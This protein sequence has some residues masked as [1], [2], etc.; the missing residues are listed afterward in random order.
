MRYIPTIALLIAVGVA[1]SFA[2]YKPE[3]ASLNSIVNADFSVSITNSNYFIREGDNNPIDVVVNFSGI[4]RPLQLSIK[5]DNPKHL[6]YMNIEMD[7]TQVN[8]GQTSKLIRFKLN[9]ENLPFKQHQRKLKLVAFNNNI[10]ISKDINFTVAPVEA[11]NVY[12]LAGQSNMVGASLSRDKVS[13]IED[14]KDLNNYDATNN[15]IKQLNVTSNNFD[16]F[17][18]PEKFTNIDLIAKPPYFITAEDP[19][20]QPDNLKGG[21]TVGLGLSFAKKVLEITEQDIILVPAAWGD[22]G[23]CKIPGRPFHSWN[24]L[25][26]GKGH[27]GGTSMFDR[28][29]ARTNFA[30][31]QSGGVLRGILWQQGE[32]DTYINECASEYKE[33]LKNIFKALRERITYDKRGDIARGELSD[34]PVTI[35]TNSRGNDERGDFSNFNKKENLIDQAHKTASSY[36]NRAASSVHDDLVPPNYPCG[37]R[38]CVHYGAKAYREMG[39]RH[40]NAYLQAANNTLNEVTAPTTMPS[41]NSGLVEGGFYKIDGTNIT[42]FNNNTCLHLNNNQSIQPENNLDLIGSSDP[43]HSFL[44]TAITDAYK[45][46][47]R[48][49]NTA[50][51]TTVTNNSTNSSQLINGTLYKIDGRNILYSSN[52]SCLKKNND[53][54]VERANN[55]DLA[56]QT[57]LRYSE[58]LKVITNAYQK[59]LACK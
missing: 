41:Q 2:N 55:L 19:L 7:S 1:F 4:N 25:A 57:D 50:L 20:H 52:G 27:L 22:T 15:K 47:R 31:K 8:S 49:Q 16:V 45:N 18:S 32:R 39:R 14:T 42:Y 35:G 28:A 36:I 9:I 34:V 33:N 11:P 44:I 26:T 40:F 10:T 24:P 21:T 17:N 30:L 13:N 29:V 46:Q 37:D 54:S 48:C 58:L 53:D 5:A 6:N 56:G 38:S 59:N 23:F 12:L 43:R 3:S 51:T